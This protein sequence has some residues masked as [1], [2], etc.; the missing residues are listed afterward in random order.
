MGEEAEATQRLLKQQQTITITNLENEHKFIVEDLER[1]IEE[2]KHE[3]RSL[4]KRVRKYKDKSIILAS[5]SSEINK[6][7]L[8]GSEFDTDTR[9]P[10]DN[11]IKQVSLHTKPIT[12]C[13]FSPTNTLFATAGEDARVC[14]FDLDIANDS[15]TQ[16]K[17]PLTAKDAITSLKFSPNGNFMIYGSYDNGARLCNIQTKK[18]KILKDHTGPVLSVAFSPDSSKALTGSRDYKIREW[19]TAN[20]YCRFSFPCQSGCK[21]MIMTEDNIVA[22]GHIDGNIRIWDL[23]TKNPQHVISG[24]HVKPIVS[25]CNAGA[26]SMLAASGDITMSE[27]DIRTFQSVQRFEDK[28]FLSTLCKAC[29]SPGGHYAVRGSDD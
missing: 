12:S 14:L 16:N 20:G 17:S 26:N 22:S 5:S 13:A 3:S 8:A 4:Q 15:W 23:R 25:L 10:Q 1:K 27:I 11:I 9:L 19:D 2:L 7:S 29:V 6:S 21:D 18:A 24:I 28:N